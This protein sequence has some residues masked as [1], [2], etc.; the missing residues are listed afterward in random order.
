MEVTI[1]HMAPATINID[2]TTVQ[3]ESIIEVV[4]V[5]IE[6]VRSHKVPVQPTQRLK[7]SL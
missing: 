1:A 3:T 6:V 4:I 7:Y 2:T 5:H